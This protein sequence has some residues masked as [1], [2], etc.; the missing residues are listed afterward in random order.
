M[1]VSVRTRFE[2]F[3]RDRFTCQY[4]GKTPPNVLLE[5]DHIIPQ[6]AG[7]SDEETNLTTSCWECNHGK[8]DRLLEEGTAPTVSAEITQR[9]AERIEQ[10]TAYTELVAQLSALQERQVQLVLD[11]WAQAWGAHAEE[12]AEGTYW[13]MPDEHGYWIER[14]T[15]RRLLRSLPL[16]YLLE[17]VDIAAA[18]FQWASWE[19]VR[20]FYGVCH[21]ERDRREGRPTHEIE[22]LRLRVGELEDENG[23]LRISVQRLL[24]D[25]GRA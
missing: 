23:N 4:C 16:D 20:Y 14:R 17:A 6:A 24:E 21:R 9:M 5:V 19:S 7:G 13:V 11:A 18:R 2:I 12:R 1:S 8:A 15:V 25:A 10:A 3:K 22:S